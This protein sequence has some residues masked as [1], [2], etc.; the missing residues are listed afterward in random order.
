MMKQ[1]G[2]NKVMLKC[3][4]HEVS[5]ETCLYAKN[6]VVANE[7]VG[8]LKGVGKAPQYREEWRSVA[9]RITGRTTPRR[10]RWSR[11]GV[12]ERSAQNRTVGLERSLRQ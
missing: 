9:N 6:Q 4:S 5:P 11:G 2:V 10:P 3:A 1:H 7:M 8:V 12:G